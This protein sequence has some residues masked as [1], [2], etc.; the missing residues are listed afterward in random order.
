MTEIQDDSLLRE[1]RDIN[2]ELIENAT[3]QACIPE[4]FEASHAASVVRRAETLSPALA[5]ALYQVSGVRPETLAA[6]EEEADAAV[7]AAYQALYGDP[8]DHL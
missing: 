4:T 6:I 1:A 5:E 8:R 2:D 3:G 7:Q